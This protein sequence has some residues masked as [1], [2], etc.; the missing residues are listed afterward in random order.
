MH[1][2]YIVCVSVLC[3]SGVE[4]KCRSIE[5]VIL[6]VFCASKVL[7]GDLFLNSIDN[8]VSQLLFIMSNAVHRILIHKY[9]MCTCTYVL[10]THSM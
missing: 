3:V 10:L 2:M 5:K 8:H 6:F 7:T 4:S 9:M 1:I